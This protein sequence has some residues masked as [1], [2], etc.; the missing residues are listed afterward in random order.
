MGSTQE[1]TVFLTEKEAERIRNTVKETVKRCSELHGKARD[2]R[3]AK[4][5]YSQATGASLMADMES[6]QSNGRGETLPALAVGQTYPPCTVASEELEPMKVSELKMNTHHRGRRLHIKRASPVVVLTARSWTMVEDAEGGDTERLEM[7]LHKSR[8][9][10]DILEYAKNFIIK[11]PYFTLTEEGEAT[12][13]IDHPSDLVSLSDA[14]T[15]KTFPSTK[16]AEK[17]A[18]T[19]KSG[20]NDELKNG[21]LAAAHEK[22]TDGLTVARQDIVSTTNPDLARDIARNRALVNL[23]LSH[24]DEAILD[25]KASLTGRGDPKSRDLDSKAYYRAGSA[26]YGLGQY[27]DAKKFFED[28]MKLAPNDKDASTYL[29]RIEMRLREQQTGA[30]NWNKIKAGLSKARPHVDAASF[31]S[32]VKV[33][34]SEGRGRGM[35][36][37]RNIPAGEMVMADKAFSVVWGHDKEAL[38][39]MTY[40]VRDDRIRVQPIGLSKAIVQKLFGNSSQISRV[41]DLFGDYDGDGK[42]VIRTEDGP[43]VDTFRIHDIVSRNGFGLG[44]QYGEEG[45]RN[46][47]TGLCTWAAYINHSCV[48]NT[49]KDFVGDLMVLRATRALNVGEE[50]F[51]SYDQNPDYE[52]RQAALMTTWGFECNCPLCAAEKADDPTVRKKRAELADQSE[53]FVRREHWAEAKRLT[54]R[55]AERLAKAIDET[56]DNERYKNVPRLAGRTIQ[57]WLTKASARK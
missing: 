15:G 39:A 5:A 18:T 57:E 32:N 2:P 19:C 25:A 1:N 42:N 4:S 21:D 55:S 37:T 45:A 30:Y 47:S 50:V 44:N 17:F 24:F 26:A 11:E 29:K 13:R 48:P 53:E 34:D 52:A 43:I 38:T 10:E 36:V 35:Y 46:A 40:D 9:G 49:S 7:S 28:Q 51:F 20:G 8:H 6:M 41:M 56:Y 3:D 16:A 27:D 33:E 22:Y 23:R 31:V 14:L 12:L 54:I